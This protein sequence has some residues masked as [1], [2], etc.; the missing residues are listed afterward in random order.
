MDTVL[1]KAE[2]I[3]VIEQHVRNLNYNKYNLEL[4]II[5]E[6]AA[7]VPSQSTIDALQLQLSDLNSKLA[8]L[9]TELDSINS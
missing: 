9:A 8:A 7:A 6:N 3:E 1:T 5:E 2:K 4:S